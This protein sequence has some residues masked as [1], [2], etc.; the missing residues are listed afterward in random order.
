M[1]WR[2]DYG[3]SMGKYV[4]ADELRTGPHGSR[5]FVIH[6]SGGTGFVVVCTIPFDAAPLVRVY[7][8]PTF[9]LVG[10]PRGGQVCAAPDNAPDRIYF[11][12]VVA[13]DGA[14]ATLAPIEP[15]WVPELTDVYLH[16]PVECPCQGWMRGPMEH[17]YVWPETLYE[18]AAKGSA[19][20]SVV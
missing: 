17:T 13:L 15:S 19:G 2:L 7:P 6:T 12:S 9:R 16:N 14:G 1:R 18:Q 4:D 10:G 8:V 5:E 3:G 20:A 11:Q